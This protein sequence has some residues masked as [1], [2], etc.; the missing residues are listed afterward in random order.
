MIE[1]KDNFCLQTSLAMVLA[2][3]VLGVWRGYGL[4]DWNLFSLLGALAIIAAALVCV[5][6][7]P[8]DDQDE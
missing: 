2:M 5:K 6:C 8:D 3:L 1:K 4:G 7:R